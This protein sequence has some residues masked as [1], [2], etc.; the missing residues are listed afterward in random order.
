MRYYIRR[1]LKT[2]ALFNE[3]KIVLTFC[4]LPIEAREEKIKS[5]SC[6]RLRLRTL[7]CV[8]QIFAINV[9]P[10]WFDIWHLRADIFPN[11]K[12]NNDDQAANR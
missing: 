1:K 12:K 10:V 9:G 2:D 6:R 11:E 5:C 4:S 3:K 8:N 7:Q